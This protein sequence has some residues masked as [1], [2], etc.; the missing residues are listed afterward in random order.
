MREFQEKKKAKSVAKSKVVLLL[1]A[2]FTFIL[3][4]SSVD[5]YKKRERVLKIKN[6]L[7]KELE[8]TNNDKALLTGDIKKLKS[9]YGVE[10]LMREK[11][12]TVWEGEGVKLI[13]KKKLFLKD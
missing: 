6:N 3:A 2:F 5:L 12:N 13:S 1:L 10:K 7:D 9:T 11:Y 8:I 4:T